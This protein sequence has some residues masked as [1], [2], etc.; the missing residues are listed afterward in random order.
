VEFG[1]PTVAVADEGADVAGEV[2]IYT[3]M[4]ES[5]V[6]AFEVALA[7]ALPAVRPKFLQSG[8][9]KIAQRA[10]MDWAAGAPR[11]CLVMTSDP[12][13][14]ADL[15]QRGLL[16]PHLPPTVLRVDRS[17]V[18]PDG[19]WVTSRISLMVLAAHEEVE[20]PPSRFTD[21]VDERWRNRFSTGDPLASGTHFTTMAFLQAERGWGFY[22]DLR[23]NGLVAAGGNSSVI[24]RVETRERPV[25]VVLLE[26]LLAA[27][28]S[29]SPAR[30][31]YPEDGA[32]VVPGPIA[33]TADC[34]NKRAARAVYD[35]VLSE[36]GQALIAAGDMYP[37]LPEIDPPPGAP[38]LDTI[39]VRPWKPGFL[40]HTRAERA[41][42]K[43]TY[44]DVVSD[45][46]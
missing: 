25:G 43:Q 33:L 34:P 24:K 41:K 14:Y 12:F 10:E 18:D 29:D 45:R 21:L 40:E 39:A 46:R 15:R 3:S 19:Y 16:E 9:E 1:A 27:A 22:A 8:S 26:N 28:R 36:R 38:R 5:V 44:E 32:I 20:S 31:V 13:W 37:A 2:W 35:F 17:L 23:A 6:D 7:E 4:Y 11:A 30:A 42:L